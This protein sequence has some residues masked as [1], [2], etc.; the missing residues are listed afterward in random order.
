MKRFSFSLQAVYD[1][2]ISQRDEAER[3]LAEAA[4]SVVAAQTKLGHLKQQQLAAIETYRRYLSQE[5][6]IRNISLQAGYLESLLKQEAK[7]QEQIEILKNVEKAKRQA[8]IAINCETEVLAK[9]RNRHHQGHK[10]QMEYLEQ[11]AFNEIAIL[12]FAHRKLE[13]R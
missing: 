4:S 12:K 5:S 8:A 3:Q 13:R 1:F 9:L 10:E 11:Q 2:K 6:D 7:E